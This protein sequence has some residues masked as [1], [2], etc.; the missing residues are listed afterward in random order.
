MADFLMGGWASQWIPQSKEAL[1][2]I[3]TFAFSKTNSMSSYP[4][5][6]KVILPGINH[7][8]GSPLQEKKGRN[9]LS[10]SFRWSK[11]ARLW[12]C[13]Y[14]T[15]S[16]SKD[17]SSANFI[18]QYLRILFQALRRQSLRVSSQSFSETFRASEVKTFP[19]YST[20]KG[21]SIPVR[22]TICTAPQ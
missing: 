5:E 9:R 10:S 14:S 13:M 19:G 16:S 7:G 11:I 8:Q 1:Y 3:L 18:I 21:C 22:V 17:S 4:I 6:K 12:M 20:R 15:V 2:R